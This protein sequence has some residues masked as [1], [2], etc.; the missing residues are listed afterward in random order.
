MLCDS[1]HHIFEII[2]LLLVAL[3]MLLSHRRYQVMMVLILYVAVFS[4][5]YF[6]STATF[7]MQQHVSSV[8]T[9]MQKALRL[10][11]IHM[12][13][14]TESVQLHQQA[15][16]EAYEAN[17]LEQESQQLQT[18]AE[19][20]HDVLSQ[21]NRQ[22]GQILSKLAA[23]DQTKAK[24]HWMNVERDQELHAQV[25]ANLTLDT[26]RHNETLQ[27]LQSK[28]QNS[29]AFCN[30]TSLFA[31]LCNAIG[32]VASLQEKSDHE[33]LLIQKEW[34][35]AAAAEKDKV[36][37]LTVA[38]LLQRQAD[39]YNATSQKLLAVAAAWD[40]RAQ[41]DY[42]ASRRDHVASTLY[43]AAASELQQQS[44]REEEWNVKSM[45]MVHVVLSQA[46]AEHVAANR[47]AV[48]AIL[49][50]AV[51]LIFIIPRA[52]T[53]VHV[54]CT[55]LGRRRG[56]LSSSSCRLP[57]DFGH[58]ASTI[59]SH[60]LIFLL[61]VGM[62]GDHLVSLQYYGIQER[63]VI[64]L[65]F[66]AV[67]A[68]CHVLLLHGIRAVYTEL[69]LT[70]ST[71]T[72]C[73]LSP[74]PSSPNRTTT[75]RD[76]ANVFL[77]LGKRLVVLLILFTMEVLFCWLTTGDE[78][79]F[80]QSVVAFL[81]TW[82]PYRLCAFAILAWHVVCMDL[83]LLDDDA[84]RNASLFREPEEESTVWLSVRRSNN[85]ATE[86]TPLCKEEILSVVTPIDIYRATAPPSEALTN[87]TTTTTT[88]S[89]AGS[90]HRRYAP[91]MQEATTASQDDDGT[92]TTLTANTLG[93]EC[94][95][96]TTT[97]A[98]NVPTATTPLSPPRHYYSLYRGFSSLLL[99]LEIF[100]I[101]CMVTI[102]STDLQVVW[103]SQARIG[104]CLALACV[105]VL[106]I[107]ACIM[108]QCWTARTVGHENDDI[109]KSSWDEVM[110]ASSPDDNGPLLLDHDHD[111]FNVSLQETMAHFSFL[112]GIRPYK[113]GNHNSN[114]FG[115]LPHFELVAV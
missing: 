13:E 14:A 42:E 51:V 46:Q 1:H 59:I 67:A 47:N 93:S 3:L 57:A 102:V 25:M 60:C 75:S 77:Q 78:F 76:W 48:Q 38:K 54:H 19:W 40:E 15:S 69:T 73:S 2:C 36:M 79:L 37:E 91:M 28:M 61:V 71:S 107:L 23:W 8:S 84:E 80:Q 22:R 106:L 88:S 45:E 114:N 52:M 85:R 105:V 41:L 43:Q 104:Q 24:I 34:D 108:I 29:A 72:T 31:S 4:L 90:N 63:A 5:A 11:T 92:M 89:A 74:S 44:Q 94:T 30:L 87:T 6:A 64:I 9:N 96:T 86:A 32:R 26:E 12:L 17:A 110:T 99:P 113:T 58:A 112:D 7:R 82:V 21:Q 35:D 70:M 100:L 83:Q 97:T 81:S 33:A 115:L 62:V 20:E 55:T 18:R 103:H 68:T 65:W 16:Y 50:A 101:T 39:E 49:C 66:A 56:L 27:E 53:K 95:T 109:T 10:T 98:R 111:D